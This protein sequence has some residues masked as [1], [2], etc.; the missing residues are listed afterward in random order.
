M[1]LRPREPGPGQAQPRVLRSWPRTG[2]RRVKV[3]DQ[4]SPLRFRKAILKVPLPLLAPPS[5]VRKREEPWGQVSRWVSE[6]PSSS[7]LSLSP[8]PQD[9]VEGPPAG[10]WCLSKCSAQ[11]GL[12]F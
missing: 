10:R 7:P 9:G 11:H 4:T 8:Q 1:G 5:E 3:S 6:G 2:A 12:E